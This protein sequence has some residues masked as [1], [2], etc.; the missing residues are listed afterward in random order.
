MIELRTGLPG[1]GKTLLAIHEVKAWA[2]RE[3]REV[4]YNGIPDLNLPWH[5][6]DDPTKW[7]E[8]P[9]NSIVLMDEAQRTFRNRSLGAIPP[10]H[11]TEL[12]THRH[13]GVDLVFITQHPSLI[14]PSVRRLAGRH[15]HSIR[16]WG[17]EAA[18]V[19]KWDSVRDNCDKPAGRKDS[20]SRK[21][22]FDK[23][24]YGV[25]KSAEVHTMKRSIPL[26]VKLL[27]LVPV[28]LAAC[29]WFTYHQ[30]HKI[31]PGVENTN[32]NT[33]TNAQAPGPER[34]AGAGGVVPGAAAPAGKQP[35][36]PVQDLK[37]YVWKETPRVAGLPQ[38]APKYDALTVPTRV[39]VPAMCIQKGSATSGREVSCKCWSQQ[40]TPMDVPFNMCMSFARDGFFREFDPDRDREGVARAEASQRALDRVPD[41]APPQHSDAGSQ[42][43]VIPGATMGPAR[44]E[45]APGLIQDGPVNNRATRAARLAGA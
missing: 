42:V 26:R 6:L 18:T 17:M 22:I 25:Y 20:E 16:V 38:T 39:P 27:A 21:W 40:G 30:L 32:K 11:V 4:Y 45:S 5:K 10:K 9:P 13:L 19:H 14:D 43:V 31:T 8:V 35:V 15:I 1:N 24:L 37:E 41:T 7:Y 28:V 12:E 2:E 34:I 23:S 29:S 3:G 36:D 44:T 33:N